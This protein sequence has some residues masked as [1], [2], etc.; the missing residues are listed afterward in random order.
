MSSSTDR[1][2]AACLRRNDT[3]VRVSRERGPRARQGG[4]L[5]GR[6]DPARRTVLDVRRHPCGGG[7]RDLP[8]RP[9]PWRFVADTITISGKSSARSASRSPFTACT[10][11]GRGGRVRVDHW[12]SCGRQAGVDEGHAQDRAR[13]S[14]AE[15]RVGRPTSGPHSTTSWRGRGRPSAPTRSTACSSSR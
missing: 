3:D 9:R 4:R 15:S 7:A 14:S 11:R 2:A 5:C 6:G 10:N 1:P 13:C 8:Q 12:I